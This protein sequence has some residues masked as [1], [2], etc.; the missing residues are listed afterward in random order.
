MQA[1]S[2]LHH[3]VP[4][5]TLLQGC[6]GFEVLRARWQALVDRLPHATYLQQ[7]GWIAGYL[8]MLDGDDRC[9]RFVTAS[10]SEG[11]L[12]AVLVLV[13]RPGRSRGLLPVLE[14]VQGPHMVL[15]DLVADAGHTGLLQAMLGWL[16]RQRAMRWAVLRLPAVCAESTLAAQLQAHP[17]RRSRRTLR[18]HS[19][20]LDCRGGVDQALKTVSKSFRTNLGRLARRANAQGELSYRVVSA[21]EELDDAFDAFLEVESSGWKRESG[22]AIA[23]DDRLVAFYRRLVREFGARGACRIHLLT[24]DGQT[25]AAQFGLI[26][27]RQLNLLKIGFSQAHAPLAP[28]NLIMLRTIEQVCA[29]PAVDR[30]SFVTD[31]L[32]SQAWRPHRSPVDHVTVYPG[33]LVGEALFRLAVWRGQRR[34]RRSLPAALPAP[35]APVPVLVQD[36]LVDAEAV[37]A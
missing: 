17:V 35:A 26:G 12:L 13:W 37:S 10:G 30:L 31:P 11:Q 28:G 18:T 7:P 14:M 21:P 6:G 22:T 9:L 36:A 25:V 2:D 20:W 5:F 3:M 15:A 16:S 34:A 29:D 1:M 4:T 27:D 24:L 19:A 8:E 33:T 32:W 23:Q